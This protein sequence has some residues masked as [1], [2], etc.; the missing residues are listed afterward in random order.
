S[1][2]LLHILSGCKTA[3]TQGRY[4]WRHDRVLRKLAEVIE[5]R[6][7]KVNKVSSP[8]PDQPVQFVRQGGEALYSIIRQRSLLSPGGEW[9]LRVDISHQLK[10]PQQTAITSLRPDIVI[11]STTTKTVIMAELT[12]PWEDGM[13]AAFERKKEKYADLA[14]AC[15]QD[16]WR[17]YTFPVE[18]GCRGF[19]GT[20]TQRFLKILGSRGAFGFGYAG[21]TRLGAEMDPR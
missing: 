16:G 3:L 11:W 13:E 12:V 15:T 17:A 20:S 6:R 7:L 19:T 1:P 21:K 5:G 10:F 18:V 4:W 9:D 2:S 14:A 8:T